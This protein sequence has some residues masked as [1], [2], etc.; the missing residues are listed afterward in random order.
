[1]VVSSISLK[2][3]LKGLLSCLLQF[4]GLSPNPI[5][6]FSMVVVEIEVCLL[7]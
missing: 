1:M 2:M 3:R 6:S 7:M 4:S 5:S